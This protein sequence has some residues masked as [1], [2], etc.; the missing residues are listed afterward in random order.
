MN[1]ASVYERLIDRAKSECRVRSIGTYYEAHHII[2]KCMGGTMPH[3][4]Q[5]RNRYLLLG[6]H[7]L[8]VHKFDKICVV[9]FNFFLT[10]F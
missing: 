10:V 8:R 7:R 5:A 6:G 2:P 1:Y 3:L 4:R 9:F